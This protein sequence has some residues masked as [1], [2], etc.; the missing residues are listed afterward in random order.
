MVHFFYIPLLYL[1]DYIKVNRCT[2]VVLHSIRIHDTNSMTYKLDLEMNQH[3]LFR[4][5]LFSFVSTGM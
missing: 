2:H 3:N 4:P 1:V 5:K